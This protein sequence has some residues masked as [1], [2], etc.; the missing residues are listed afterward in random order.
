MDRRRDGS[1]RPAHTSGDP[2]RKVR[3]AAAAGRGAGNSSSECIRAQSA[4]RVMTPSEDCVLSGIRLPS[5][6]RAQSRPAARAGR[7]LVLVQECVR[8]RGGRFI[9]PR[10]APRPRV[11][12]VASRCPARP[13]VPGTPAAGGQ[14]GGRTWSQ[15]PDDRPVRGYHQLLTPL[16]AERSPAAA[17]RAAR[18]RR[19][20]GCGSRRG[21][22][23][24]GRARA[25]GVSRLRY[26][27]R[28]E[29]CLSWRL[30]SPGR[31]FDDLFYRAAPA[32]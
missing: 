29:I 4:G 10:A 8:S 15:A 31:I 13:V 12:P 23:R 1:G 25:G 24:R 28:P 27:R 2:W 16:A 22:T 7:C 14:T 30:S 32:R 3:P 6:V 21:I 20:P 17:R 5:R 11:C 26:R 18:R 19:P 9:C